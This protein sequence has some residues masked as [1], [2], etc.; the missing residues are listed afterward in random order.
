MKRRNDN[1]K[2]RRNDN[3]NLKLG[4]AVFCIRGDRETVYA[5]VF[6][7]NSTRWCHL[8]GHHL[9]ELGMNY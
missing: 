2:L 8:S 1:L 4:I 6:M 5:D 7:P 3:D 9:G